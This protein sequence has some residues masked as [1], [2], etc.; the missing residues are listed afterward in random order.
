MRRTAEAKYPVKPMSRAS[1]HVVGE[2]ARDGKYEE[3]AKGAKSIDKTDL[4]RIA[5]QRENVKRNV[6][7]DHA[8]AEH[9]QASGHGQHYQVTAEEGKRKGHRRKLAEN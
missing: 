4:N 3:A 7:E 5:A 8:A 9:P 2:V 6:G 1:V